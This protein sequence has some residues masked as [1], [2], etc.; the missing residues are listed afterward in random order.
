MTSSASFAMLMLFSTPFIEAAPARRYRT[1]STHGSCGHQVSWEFPRSTIYHPSSGNCATTKFSKCNGA[2][3]DYR[4]CSAFPLESSHVHTYT[5]ARTRTPLSSTGHRGQKR[6]DPE[7]AWPLPRPETSVARAQL[8][9]CLRKSRK[10]VRCFLRACIHACAQAFGATR[11]HA[12]TRRRAHAGA[13]THACTKIPIDTQ[14]HTHRSV[15][16]LGFS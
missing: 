13:H 5:H 9:W 2:S 7:V 1:C 4:L 16:Y 6:Y 3:H 10:V 12:R 8:G 14:N 15:S 11:S